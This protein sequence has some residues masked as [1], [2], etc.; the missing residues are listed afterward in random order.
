MFS[1]IEE[2]DSNM[3]RAEKINDSMETYSKKETQQE[4]STSKLE[5]YIT[6]QESSNYFSF[7]NNKTDLNEKEEHLI[8][9][10][11]STEDVTC[12]NNNRSIEIPTTSKFIN[13]DVSQNAQKSLSNFIFLNHERFFKPNKRFFMVFYN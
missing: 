10:S 11:T 3:I 12:L 8:S 5:Q 6:P 7:I 9:S 13:E 4:T 1:T 2:T